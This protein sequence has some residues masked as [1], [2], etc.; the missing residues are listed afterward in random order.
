MIFDISIAVIAASVAVLVIFL[1]VTLV[2]TQKTLIS[3]KKDL[4]HLTNETIQLIQK[5][6]ALTADIQSKSDSLNFV[7]RPLKALGKEHHKDH[8]S[9]T[10]HDIANWV[11]TSLVLFDK[12]KTAVRRY[13]R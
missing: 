6:D 4:H 7:F 5:L 9:D 11:G 1:S 12:I 2:K 10:V 13:E 8:K 3:T